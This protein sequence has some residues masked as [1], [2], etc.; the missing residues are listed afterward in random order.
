MKVF[1]LAVGIFLLASSMFYY[2]KEDYGRANYLATMAIGNI[3]IGFL[4]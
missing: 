3:I 4:E 1:S 2:F